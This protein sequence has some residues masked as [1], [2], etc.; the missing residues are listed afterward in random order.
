MPADEVCG[1]GCMGVHPSRAPRTSDD[2]V[3]PATGAPSQE[4]RSTDRRSRSPPVPSAPMPDLSVNLAGVT[5]AN[6]VVLAAGT[7]GYVNELADA[8]PLNRIGAVTTKSIT[9]ESRDGDR[10]SVV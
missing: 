4:P 2:E 8:F 5:L 6:P 10:K 7:C 9:R 1:T 3:A